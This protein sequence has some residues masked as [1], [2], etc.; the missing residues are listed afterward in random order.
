M[1]K[2]IPTQFKEGDILAHNHTK[3]MIRAC[4]IAFSWSGA[5]PTM[6]SGVTPAGRV[7]TFEE[8][9]CHKATK[10]DLIEWIRQCE[11]QKPDEKVVM[12]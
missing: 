5:F 2:Q 10:E 3:E 1:S 12:Q 8:Q 6:Y 9:D 7:T 4:G 11:D